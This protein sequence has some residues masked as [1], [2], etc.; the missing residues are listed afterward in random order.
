[1]QAERW[2]E[3]DQGIERNPRGGGRDTNR[4]EECEKRRAREK[5]EVTSR[6]TSEVG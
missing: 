4:K 5:Y 6:I 1:M 3:S 2:R